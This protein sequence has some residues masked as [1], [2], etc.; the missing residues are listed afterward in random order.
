MLYCLESMT[1][2]AS[3]TATGK[4]PRTSDVQD[5]RDHKVVRRQGPSSKKESDRIDDNDDDDDDEEEEEKEEEE[6][7]EEEKQVKPKPTSRGRAKAKAKARTEED[8]EVEVVKKPKKKR[9][10]RA[11]SPS[12]LGGY[13]GEFC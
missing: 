6:E 1:K 3:A 12:D 2:T 9:V 10:E 13:E 5:E 4:R 8:E 11:E 7:E